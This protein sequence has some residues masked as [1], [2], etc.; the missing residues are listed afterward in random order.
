M[1]VVLLLRPYQITNKIHGLPSHVLTVAAGEKER[2]EIQ[3][4]P[5]RVCCALSCLSPEARIFT[6]DLGFLSGHICP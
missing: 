4:M 1:E 6:T 3:R 5:H 2:K